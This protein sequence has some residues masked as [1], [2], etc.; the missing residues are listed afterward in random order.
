MDLVEY[1]C[2]CQKWEI[3]SI[4]CCQ[5]ISC[6][7]FNRED[8]EKHVNDR[9]KVNAYKACYEPMMEPINWASFRATSH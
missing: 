4:P 2:S 5:A 8:V 9:Y 1:K 6:I 3:T 7:F